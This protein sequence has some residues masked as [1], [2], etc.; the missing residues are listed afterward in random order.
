[1]QIFAKIDGITGRRRFRQTCKCWYMWTNSQMN[2]YLRQ[3]YVP[4]FNR[5]IMTISREMF[6]VELCVDKLSIPREYW[7]CRCA[8]LFNS[9]DDFIDFAQ[10]END[11]NENNDKNNKNNN[12]KYDKDKNHKIANDKI[13]NV[14]DINFRKINISLINAEFKE[15]IER[16]IG[17]PIEMCQ[18]ILESSDNSPNN[19]PN[20]EKNDIS[21]LYNIIDGEMP[22]NCA[23]C[24]HPRNQVAVKC[25]ILFGRD[26]WLDELLR[27]GYRLMLRDIKSILIC[28]NVSLLNKVAQKLTDL[29]KSY[30]HYLAI[31]GHVDMYEWMKARGHVVSA[32]DI[33]MCAKY[34]HLEAIQWMICE[35]C[36]WS[37]VPMWA[38][39][40][41]HLHVLKWA[42]G[43]G[44]P[45]WNEEYICDYAVRGGNIEVLH[46][47]RA[48]GCP[49]NASVLATA[50]ETGNDEIFDWAI[51]NGCP[52]DGL[53]LILSMKYGNSVAAH[54]EII[55]GEK[56]NNGNSV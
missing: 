37:N 31:G 8:N 20:Y 14:K 45:N 27:C 23:M 16:Q 15:L 25:A 29:P 3:Y 6:T 46:W 4:Y 26:D 5:N 56:I 52:T 40:G 12:E 39:F 13:N 2:D 33:T 51:D 44:C 21:L 1:M 47:L 22:Q 50:L 36:D 7:M 48:N 34:G 49:W 11:N 17:A 30:S 42:K 9:T 24:R 43:M 18:T 35:G 55:V 28:G 19:S 53:G 10:N 38:A 41:G 54:W 32:Y